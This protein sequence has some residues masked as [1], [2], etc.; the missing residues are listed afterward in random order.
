MVWTDDRQAIKILTL[1]EECT[2]EALAVYPARRI[3][4]NDVIG[5]FA[6]VMVERSVP[7]YIRIDNGPEKIAK[8]LRDWLTRVG[9]RTIL[10]GS[11]SQNGYC[12]S[13][14]GKLRN[15]LLDGEGFY[16]LRKAQVII[17]Q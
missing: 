10:L 2:R 8:V 7:E 13:F 14:D 3:R 11:P 12:E 6:D 16:T 4:A 15:E 1:I 9:T 17:E 5:I